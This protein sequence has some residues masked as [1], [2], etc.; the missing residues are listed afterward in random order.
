MKQVDRFQLPAAPSR[1]EPAIRTRGLTC[2]FGAKAAL[3]DM[4]I[5]VPRG[6]VFAFL[7]RAAR[8]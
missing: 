6:G 4:N 7:G 3:L 2:Y 8:R 5:E 1:S